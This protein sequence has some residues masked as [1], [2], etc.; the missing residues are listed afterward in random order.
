MSAASVLLMT[1]DQEGS[2]LVRLEALERGMCIVTTRT[3]GLLGVLVEPTTDQVRAP[4]IFIGESERDLVN[5]LKK[6]FDNLYWTHS[7]INA[8]RSLVINLSPEIIAQNY[9]NVDFINP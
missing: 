9:L 8:R 3:S 2:P 6:S 5:H 7:A 4:G 1:S